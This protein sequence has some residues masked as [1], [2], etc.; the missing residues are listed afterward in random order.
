MFPLKRAIISF[1]IFLLP[2]AAVNAADCLKIDYE[3][4]FAEISF[5]YDENSAGSYTD[6]NGYIL[7]QFTL[8][9]AVPP[10]DSYY[11]EALDY[12]T[13]IIDNSFRKFASGAKTDIT[14]PDASVGIDPLINGIIRAKSG[15]LRFQQIIAL[16][17]RPVQL[18]DG[19]ATLYST[20]K[21]RLHYEG[22]KYESIRGIYSKSDYS[23]MWEETLKNLLVNYEYGKSWRLK[24]KGTEMAIPPFLKNE[25]SPVIRLTVTKDNIYIVKPKLFYFLGLDP[26]T[27]DPRTF[28]L[29]YKGEEVPIIVIG[30]E[31]GIFDNNDY[32]L[33]FG[34]SVERGEFYR[35]ILTD[36]SNYFLIYSQSEGKRYTVHSSSPVGEPNAVAFNTSTLQEKNLLHDIYNIYTSDPMA[37]NFFWKRI[38]APSQ[39]IFAFAVNNIAQDSQ[40]FIFKL[41]LSGVT[42]L[43][44]SPDHHFIVKLNNTQ[45]LEG[46]FDGRTS[47]MYTAQFPDSLLTNGLNILSVQSV[48][49]TVPDSIDSIYVDWF[50]IV[51]NA[52]YVMQKGKLTFAR[53][54]IYTSPFPYTFEVDNINTSDVLLLDTKNHVMFTDYTM[55]FNEE[56]GR[57]SLSFTDDLIHE[58]NG[59]Q[60]LKP[61]YFLTLRK[62]VKKPDKAELIEVPDLLN[63]S[64]RADLLMIYHAEF[65]DAVD[66]LKSFYESKGF[67]VY[68]ARIDHIYYAFNNGIVSIPSIRS[69]LEGVFN[70]WEKVPSHVT[71]IGGTTYDPM[72]F[73]EDSFKGL[74][75]PAWGE[76]A[77]DF[78]YACVSGE[79]ELLDYFLSR[80]P[81]Q[82][83][84]EAVSYAA[85]AMEFD[86]NP[87]IG[88]WQK[89]SLFIN[90]GFNSSEQT[91]FSYQTDNIINDI[92]CPNTSAKDSYICNTYV[93]SKTTTG[94]NWDEY[95]DEINQYITDGV[96]IINFFGHAGSMTWDCMYSTNSVLA[97]S[98]SPKLPV[99][100]SNTCFTAAFDSP[101]LYSLSELFTS[102]QPDG[103]A[104]V[105][106]GQPLLGY[107]WG[108]YYLA[109]EFFTGFFVYK[110]INI[111]QVLT[112]AKLRFYLDYF[113]DYVGTYQM[114]NVIGDGFMNIRLTFE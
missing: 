34:R 94:C 99:I 50:Q 21:I 1:F 2:F 84:E 30:E 12:S 48:G 98:N 95:K 55:E 46:F 36:E 85:K 38:D 109:R 73:L 58:G 77:N 45:I 52:Y 91:I 65:Q 28:Q 112:E 69:F 35:N 96:S 90:G 72:L 39:K 100:F 101:S 29:F 82:T 26:S 18:S 20:L 105:F 106:V 66:T 64:N 56:T 22:I 6:S 19:S 33:F 71:F 78:Y 79:D 104:L 110:D 81:A 16:N 37:D 83:A 11:I 75:I 42:A 47:H 41:F 63:P 23:E 68:A 93:V 107:M 70:T 67:E 44:E 111:G 43:E 24:Q 61:S 40:D 97:L 10:S 88:D 102:Y 8:N 113:P 15:I 31:D 86:T 32:I 3:S 80:I 27:I 7:P 114:S 49:D 76:P 25:S 51:Y 13:V 108:G 5:N 62:L 17:I 57:Y 87:F 59:G 103:G 92:I 60:P 74:F 89:M 53:P 14:I 9:L 54:R 4:N